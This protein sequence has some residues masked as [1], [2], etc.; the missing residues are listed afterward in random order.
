MPLFVESLTP[1]E[2][3]S[4]IIDFDSEGNFKLNADLDS[5]AL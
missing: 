3:S 5:I 1:N 4:I 2:L